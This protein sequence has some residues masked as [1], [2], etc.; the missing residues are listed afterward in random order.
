MY[1]DIFQ[2]DL[3]FSTSV[4]MAQKN[5]ILLVLLVVAAS[6][7]LETVVVDSQTFDNPTVFKIGTCQTL[8]PFLGN[9]TLTFAQRVYHAIDFYTEYHVKGQ[10]PFLINGNY[11]TIEVELQD[12]E[13]SFDIMKK[14]FTKMYEDGITAFL[15]PLFG[16]YEGVSLPKFF[17]SFEYPPPIIYN[18]NSEK[19]VIEYP[20]TFFTAASQYTAFGSTLSAAVIQGARNIT[21][22]WSISDPANEHACI[23]A[24]SIGERFGMKN[25]GVN[26]RLMS[27][28]V[29]DT[30]S[31]TLVYQNVSATLEMIRYT[32]N[33]DVLLISAYPEV[34]SAVATAL[35]EQN[36]TPKLVAFS[37]YLIPEQQADVK[38][39]QYF[40]ASAPWSSSLNFTGDPYFGTSEEFSANYEKIT[41]VQPG[42]ID[43][44][45][46]LTLYAFEIGLRDAIERF[47]IKDGSLPNINDL[48]FSVARV[49]EPT[50]SGQL[51]FDL[52]GQTEV[53]WTSIQL[54][55][56]MP[57]YNQFEAIAQNETSANG[58]EPRARQRA[59]PLIDG[60]YS[61][62]PVVSPL[63]FSKTKLVYPV[64]TYE[65]RE[66]DLGY[67]KYTEEI[68]FTVLA[69]V[70][71]LANVVLIVLLFVW[72]ENDTL[73]KSQPE[74]IQL[75]LLGFILVCCSIFSWQLYVTEAGCIASAWL[76]GVGLC[77]I[78]AAQI[79]RTI[80]ITR[81]M[82]QTAKMR[83]TV[84][85]LSKA[86]IIFGTLLIPVLILLVVLCARGA[87]DSQFV[88]DI[89]RPINN[90]TECV[91]DTP[92]VEVIMLGAYFCILL[93]VWACILFYSYRHLQ[94]QY[95]L[96]EIV[97]S[98]GSCCLL[99]VCGVVAVVIEIIDISRTIQYTIRCVVILIC[100]FFYIL[101]IIYKLYECKHGIG[102]VNSMGETVGSSA[103]LGGRPTK[104]SEQHSTTELSSVH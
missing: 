83:S 19:A 77:F 20:N 8:S 9:Y 79:S 90:Y 41:G 95:G 13:L 86:L 27:D 7:I 24:F 39:A 50:F 11:Y 62:S 23:G 52:Y 80:R 54:N 22:M 25:S 49:S 76:L 89:L 58:K 87:V 96:H 5:L 82:Q 28:A 60:N 31:R 35:R 44:S 47:D 67:Y 104:Q 4:I 103:S 68:V 48:L 21:C 18:V 78:L 2:V 36:W 71:I 100:A 34:V 88:V 1:F 84:F 10:G 45:T 37:P 51:K 72:K 91:L 65:E 6:Q 29:D 61:N 102:G 99:S 97:A 43:V 101:S 26:Y 46:V 40:V 64:P 92:Y 30:P 15:M 55:A 32:E 66:E 56:D 59:E 17:S 63:E 33:P 94:A 98:I 75:V 53:P 14:Q 73:R 38:D 85:P 16:T 69:A 70:V 74:F 93:I 3:F 42:A 12:Y 81:V 57:A